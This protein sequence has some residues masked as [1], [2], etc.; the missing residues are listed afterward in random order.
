[1]TWSITFR[2]RMSGRVCALEGDDVAPFPLLVQ[3]VPLEELQPVAV[4]F[5]GAPGVGLYQV[6]EVGSKFG[7][8]EVIEAAVNVRGNPPRHS[9]IGVK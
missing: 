9:E 8:G 1:M 5:D 6:A 7:N 2:D 4:E 3:H